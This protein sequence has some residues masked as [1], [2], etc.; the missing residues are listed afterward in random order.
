[1]KKC[2]SVLGLLLVVSSSVYAGQ[3]MDQLLR[4]KVGEVVAF[5]QGMNSEKARDLAVQGL[6]NLNN[7]NIIPPV[8]MG[9][10][11]PIAQNLDLITQAVTASWDVFVSL[12]KF[13]PFIKDVA[14]DLAPQVRDAYGIT[15]P[16]LRGQ[17]DQSGVV[18]DLLI[19]KLGDTLDMLLTK[20]QP[21]LIEV[22][23]E[24][25]GTEAANRLK[26]LVSEIAF[27]NGYGAAINQEKID[28]V[29]VQILNALQNEQ[30]LQVLRDGIRELRTPGFRDRLAEKF[31][32]EIEALR[33]IAGTAI[34][35]IR[36]RIT[37]RTGMTPEQLIEEAK[38][39]GNQGKAWVEEK[40]GRTFEEV[41]VLAQEKV[42]EVRALAAQGQQRVQD[43]VQQ[44]MA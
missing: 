34:N 16:L 28:M 43:L 41:A 9:V 3:P 14:L 19:I 30:L 17:M 37:D 36:E 6:Q 39:L 8:A 10:L 26:R 35:E 40:T 13:F 42:D 4:N 27:K 24:L 32:P 33:R 21:Q 12:N 25:Q 1:M 23:R 38:K 5:A 20:Y 22:L 31:A 7:F 18:A 2:L 29:I 15:E 44:V 11:M